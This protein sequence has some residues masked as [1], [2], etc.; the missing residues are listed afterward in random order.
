MRPLVRSA[1]SAAE[2]LRKAHDFAT[3]AK[4]M[5]GTSF[6]G[7]R[8]YSGVSDDLEAEFRRKFDPIAEEFQ[9]HKALKHPFFDFLAEQSQ[10]GFTSKQFEIYRDNFFRRTEL[11]IPSVARFIEKAALSGDSQAVADTIR[12]L[13][14]EGGYGDVDKMHS[15]LL[16]KSHNVHGMRVFNVNPVYPLS[17]AGKSQNLVPEVLEYRKAKQQAFEQAYPFIAGNTWAHELAA[18]DMLDNFRKAFFAP[19]RGYYTSEEYQK[20]TEFFT[21]HKDDSVE[22]GD[23]EAQ[24]ERMARGAAERA[25]KESLVNILDVRKGGLDFLSHQ[26]R[27]WDGMLREIE[28][29]RSQGE[30][31]E[32]KENFSP[33][34]SVKSSEAKSAKGSALEKTH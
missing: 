33:S 2:N 12:N 28:K 22:G 27:L 5:Y 7:S 4:R 15:N 1:T 21:A 30:L 9:S 14:D 20:V 18:D 6:G 16:A 29:A 25:C 23:V 17:E 3:V 8:G 13:S 31:I 11:T 19:Y 24:H 10:E 32:L 26:E 34:P